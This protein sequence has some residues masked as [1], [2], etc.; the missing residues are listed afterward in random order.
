MPPAREGLPARREWP[1]TAIRS[2]TLRR[3]PHRAPFPRVR[4]GEHRTGYAAQVPKHVRVRKLSRPH[5]KKSMPFE[6]FRT[7]AQVVNL[8]D[9]EAR[10]DGGAAVT[11]EAH[12]DKRLA[13]RNGV[14]VKILAKGEISKPL[15]VHAHGF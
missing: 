13:T 14:A 11:I 7:Q 10:F 8:S 5:I 4:S 1:Q 6:P 2:L 3:L 12:A 15:T 9:L